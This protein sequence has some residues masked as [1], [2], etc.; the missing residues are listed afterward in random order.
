MKK[1][2]G[3]FVIA[4]KE[5]TRFFFDKRM[6]LSTLLL[7]G[8]L[9]Y[10]LYSFMGSGMG[11]MFGTDDDYVPTVY[12]ENVPESMKDF[13][14]TDALNMYDGTLDKDTALSHV[15][16][17]ELDAAVFFGAD[18][19]EALSLRQT[20]KTA[21]MPEVFLYYNTSE[22][23]SQPA[24]LLLTAFFENYEAIINPPVISVNGDA[25]QVY[26]LATEEDISADIFSLMMPLLLM[27]MIFSGCMAVAPESIAGEKERGTIATLLAT[28]LDR[29][30]LALGKIVS[31]S[32]IALLSG[33]SSFIGIMLSLPKLMG[34]SMGEDVLTLS[35]YGVGDYAALLTVILS[36]VLLIVAAVSLVSG[37]AKSVKEATTYVSPLMIVVAV[38]G[39]FS[40]F[41]DDARPLASYVAPLYNSVCCIRDVFSGVSNTL[42]ILMT[43]LSNVGYT[44]VLIF[45]LTR[46]FESERVMF[47]K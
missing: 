22:S 2:N 7:P 16:S 21:P 37:F 8:L 29:R 46:M 47:R 17:G 41:G 18:F 15:K 13:F 20:D 34:G 32:M 24:Y 26:D 9:I 45:L 27:M 25:E 1:P 40:M 43:T 5:L 30:Q 3:F 44:A 33:M 10:I 39:V 19:D 31:L 35:L 23:N 42:G 36:S 11:S 28:P 12:A 14:A 38:L 4:K 6:V